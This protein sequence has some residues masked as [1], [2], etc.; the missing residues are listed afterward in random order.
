VLLVLMLVGSHIYTCVAQPTCRMPLAAVWTQPAVRCSKKRLKPGTRVVRSECANH[1]GRSLRV[2]RNRRGSLQAWMTSQR[3]AVGVSIEMI[4]VQPWMR[5]TDR[6]FDDRDARAEMYTQELRR[7]QDGSMARH[8]SLQRDKLVFCSGGGRIAMVTRKRFDRGDV[9]KE[10]SPY[11]RD[12]SQHS[13][14][15]QDL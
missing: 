8:V 6:R 13:R 9:N 1:H 15:R 11:V 7:P 2:P 3:S 12:G 10:S 5:A 4:E 14:S